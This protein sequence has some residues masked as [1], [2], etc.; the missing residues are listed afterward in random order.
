MECKDLEMGLPAIRRRWR[1]GHSAC[2]EIGPVSDDLALSLANPLRR[3]LLSSLPGAAIT[4][5]RIEGVQHEYQ[6]ILNIKEDVT[7]IVQN[8][9]QIRLCSFSDRA[10]LM[11]LDAQG[12]GIVTAADIHAPGSIEIINP[13]LHIATLDNANARLSME[14]T[15]NVGRGFVAFDEQDAR[16]MPRGVIPIDAIY[17][18]IRHVNFTLEDGS[19]TPILLE[20]T[21]DGTLSPDEALRQSAAILIRQLAGLRDWQR[22]ESRDT[23]IHLVPIPSSI[24]ELSMSELDL[25]PRIVNSLK[26]YGIVTV[27][28]LLELSD[29]D[30]LSLRNI[31]E[32][33][34]REIADALRIKGLLRKERES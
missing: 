22:P 31:G 32:K 28:P 12:E 33:A 7:E 30:I 24:Y 6:D 27:G 4:A 10:V 25:Q 9:K 8:L 18:P 17:S 26:R 1:Q 21:T 14:M 16:Q 29:T 3:V 11:H 34:L 20:I 5:V 23:D 19:L 15:V 2:Y 13:D